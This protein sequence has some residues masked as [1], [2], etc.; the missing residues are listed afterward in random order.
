M[1][2]LVVLDF[3]QFPSGYHHRV[4]QHALLVQDILEARSH[5]Q[6]PIAS[7]RGSSW[8][9]QPRLVDLANGVIYWAHH[10][11]M[12]APSDA[13][14][15]FCVFCSNWR[16]RM[17]EK[18]GKSEDWRTATKHISIYFISIQKW[19]RGLVLV[20]TACSTNET[21]GLKQWTWWF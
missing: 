12:Y 20:L 3:W 2:I 9:L 13:Q 14:G 10:S 8:Q 19:S 4:P 11:R 16:W 7:P 21:S 18:D 6:F 1:I 15:I 17:K 5:P